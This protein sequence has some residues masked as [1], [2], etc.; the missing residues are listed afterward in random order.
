[1]QRNKYVRRPIYKEVDRNGKML[2]GLLEKEEGSYSNGN[3]QGDEEEEITFVDKGDMVID[4]MLA[5]EKVR[6]GI[7]RIK[8]GSKVGA[9][10]LPVI[11]EL[12]VIRR[13]RKTKYWN[14]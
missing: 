7:K 1:M 3:V 10:H 2:V 14:E 5:D 11:L 8:T 12:V 9:E 6:M 4:Y 13:G